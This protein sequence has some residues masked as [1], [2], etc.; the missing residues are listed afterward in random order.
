M[1]LQV[2]IRPPQAWLSHV[3]LPSN[4]PCQMKPPDNGHYMLNF[5]RAQLK[6]SETI[7]HQLGIVLDPVE[8]TVFHAPIIEQSMNPAGAAFYSLLDD[9]DREASMKLSGRECWPA[10]KLNGGW[11][12]WHLNFPA[13]AAAKDM[14]GYMMHLIATAARDEDKE[15]FLDGKKGRSFLHFSSSSSNKEPTS[16]ALTKG[17]RQRKAAAITIIIH[18]FLRTTPRGSEENPNWFPKEFQVSRE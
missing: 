13:F 3:L 16:M 15:H 2:G 4:E 9:I 18:S 5:T 14:R 7:Q 17:G 12:D 1:E 11:E 10:M 6:A 8:E